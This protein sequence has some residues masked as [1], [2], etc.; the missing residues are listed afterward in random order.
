MENMSAEHRQGLRVECHEVPH[1]AESVWVTDEVAIRLPAG[2]TFRDV[3]GYDVTMIL[4]KFSEGIRPSEVHVRALDGSEPVDGAV[5]RR[6]RFAELVQTATARVLV[7]QESRMLFASKHDAPD[8]TR[9]GG[10]IKPTDQALRSLSSKHRLATQ[11]G[12]PPSQFVQSAMGLSRA[13]AGYWIKLARERG[14]LE[15]SDRGRG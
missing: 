3:D 2:V 15:R 4:D 9:T 8:E 1:D 10:A 12:F 14:F 6:L 7:D 5:M 13:T 11:L